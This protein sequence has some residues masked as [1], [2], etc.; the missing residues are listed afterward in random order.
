MSSLISLQPRNDNFDTYIHE[1]N[2]GI[3]QIPEFQRDFIWDLEN[4]LNLLRSIKKNY[5]IGSFLFWKPTTK[6]KISKQIGP[7]FIDED[8]IKEFEKKEVNKYVLDGYQRISTLFGVLTNPKQIINYRIDKKIYNDTFRIFYNLKEE[9]FENYK[10]DNNSLETYIIPVYTLL[11]FEEFLSV[12]QKIQNSYDLEDAL[13]YSNRLKKIVT[14]FERYQMPVIEIAGGSL[15]EAIDIFTLLNKE[16]KPI[17][18]DWILSAKTYSDDFRLGDLIDKVLEQLEYYNFNDKRQKDNS[19][20]ELIF[21]SIQS[22]FGDLYLDT[23]KTDI[24]TL[25]K[26]SNFKEQVELTISSIEKAVRFIFEHLL[27]VDNKLLPSGMQLIFLVEYFNRVDDNLH[28]DKILDLKEWFWLTSFA[29]YF[30]VYNP[31]KRKQAFSQ[32][33]MFAEDKDQIIFTTYLDSLST[34][35]L[36]SEMPKKINFGSVRSKA[37]ILFMLNYSNSFRKINVDNVNGYKIVKLFSNLTSKQTEEYGEIANSIVCL[38]FID[39]IEV[40][41]NFDY[42]KQKDYSFLLSEEFSGEY[43]NFFIT[44]EMRQYFLSNDINSIL[45][46]RKELIDIAEK[47]FVNEV[48]SILKYDEK[49]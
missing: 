15:D 5:P 23:K 1:I 25:S 46:L 39:G 22:S 32:F 36:V 7:Y 13:L 12:S 33:Q 6:F 34:P 38:E 40:E 35:F 3:I 30:T 43:L 17:T 47:E 9:E 48:N 2:S 31:S 49:Y 4:V 26:K 45:R 29:N 27:I 44:D 19:V 10:N 37:S 18:P 20:K 28:N 41:N 8:V 24:I 14:T 11:N 42:K 16:G 21:R